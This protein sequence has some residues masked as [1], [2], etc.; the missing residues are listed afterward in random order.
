VEDQEDEEPEAESCIPDQFQFVRFI[1]EAMLKMLAFVDAIVAPPPNHPDATGQA[2]GSRGGVL[3]SCEKL[4]ALLD[5][6]GALAKALSQLGLPSH[7]DPSRHSAQVVRVQA[8]TVSLLSAKEGKA[9]EAI[10]TMEHNGRG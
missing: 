10:W 9:G 2:V 8:E 5:V 7:P 6:R 4:H 1:Q 3:A